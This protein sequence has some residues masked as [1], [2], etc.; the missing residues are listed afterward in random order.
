M[1]AENK[2]IANLI[3]I[4]LWHGQGYQGK[5]LRVAVLDPERSL[6]PYQEGV[7]Q[8]PLG[9]SGKAGGHVGQCCAVIQQIAPQAELFA[10]GT[11]RAAWEWVLANDIDIVS[12]SYTAGALS[13]ALLPRLERSKL[14]TFAAAGNSGDLEDGADRVYPGGYDWTISVGAYCPNLDRLEPYTNGGQSLDCVVYTDWAVL[15]NQGK[16]IEFNGTSCATAVA[17]GMMALVLQKEGRQK[18]WQWAREFIKEHSV[19]ILEA[20]KDL[21]SGYGLFCLPEPPKEEKNIEIKMKIDSKTAYVD[22]KAVQLERAPE[23]KDGCT[24]V[25]VRFVAEALGCQV[26]YS[27]NTTREITIKG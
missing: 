12:C 16:P 9:E 13:A 14:L 23:E 19:D 6:Y 4:P 11:D 17:A 27:G 8:R 7:V 20:G 3:N 26:S 24:L 10:L 22:G 1:L 25:P 15:N 18:G 5:G 21:A 2:A